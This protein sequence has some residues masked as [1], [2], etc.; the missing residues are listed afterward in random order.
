MTGLLPIV[1]VCLASRLALG[2]PNG[3]PNLSCKELI[4]GH[5]RKFGR[6]YFPI[7]DQKGPSNYIIKAEW[8][9][10]RE[11][12]RVSITGST[13]QGFLIQARETLDGPAVGNFKAISNESQYLDCTGDDFKVCF[14]I[15][16]FY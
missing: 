9:E 14:N 13:L 4:P 5:T 8:D 12:V 6:H 3:A 10:E 16:I 15:I 7:S 11:F 2:H 1:L